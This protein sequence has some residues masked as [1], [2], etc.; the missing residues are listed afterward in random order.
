[1]LEIV[2]PV[3]AGF[4]LCLVVTAF[5]AIVIFC[6]WTRYKGKK[7]KE[8][9][10]LGHHT[11]S[12]N[13]KVE[14]MKQDCDKRHFCDPL[15]KILEDLVEKEQGRNP[16]NPA[17]IAQLEKRLDDVINLR[18]KISQAAAETCQ[19]EAEE[20]RRQADERHSNSETGGGLR[21]DG[22]EGHPAEDGPPVEDSEGEEQR[23]G[24]N[25][26]NFC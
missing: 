18:T 21:S 12:A 3:V 25:S 14:K 17:R 23:K 24:K 7:T 19:A 22:T 6:L 11:V 20:Q 8:Q 13:L 16:R 4:S 15:L 26:G 5:A 9:V 10:D 1:M 2:I